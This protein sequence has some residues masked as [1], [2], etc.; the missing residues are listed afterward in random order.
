VAESILYALRAAITRR[1]D[2]IVDNVCVVVALSAFAAKHF[3]SAGYPAGRIVVLPNAVALPPIEAAPRSGEYVAYA[4]RL[5]Y[6]KGADLLVGAAV[7]TGL[8]VR[9]A[10]NTAEAEIS[11]GAVPDNV[12]FLGSLPRARMAEFYSRA[13]FCVVPSR[14]F[15]MCP[16]VVLEAMSFGLPV[17]AFGVGGMAELIVDGETGLLCDLDC[18]EDLAVKMRK[19]WDSPDECARLGAAARA[20]VAEHFNESAYFD[21]LMKVYRG[22]AERGY[23][24]KC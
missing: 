23:R 13:R 6:S 9:L 18:P 11:T 12:T 20:R 24:L 16:L 14:W 1:L 8:P 10:G 5:T 15:E 7:R 2:L 17:I 21:K 19:L 4:G 3:E 22:A